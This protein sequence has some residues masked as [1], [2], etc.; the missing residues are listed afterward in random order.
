M[1]DIY[2]F[3]YQQLSLKVIAAKLDNI[4]AQNWLEFDTLVTNEKH[5]FENTFSTYL[6]LKCMVYANHAF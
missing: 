2:L 1:F 4:Y 5:N 6:S 3:F